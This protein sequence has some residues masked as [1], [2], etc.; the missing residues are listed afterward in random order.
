MGYICL[1]LVILVLDG[2]AIATDL[3]SRLEKTGRTRYH[4]S[5]DTGTA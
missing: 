3:Y 5:D 4:G 2:M 1:K